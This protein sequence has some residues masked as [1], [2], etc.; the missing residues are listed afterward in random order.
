[1][2]FSDEYNTILQN[3]VHKDQQ[4]HKKKVKHEYSLDTFGMTEK[5][6]LDA[7]SEYMQVNS[8]E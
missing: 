6:I 3:Y 1:M 4:A 2:E 5:E 7:F 8:Y